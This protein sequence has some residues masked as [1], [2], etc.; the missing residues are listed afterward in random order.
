MAMPAPQPGLAEAPI[1]RTVRP[2]GFPGHR[3][4][5]GYCGI[6]AIAAAL[7]RHV[8]AYWSMYS[9]SATLTAVT[10]QGACPE[11]CRLYVVR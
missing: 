10:I 2:R 5:R 1:L 8:N 9:R 11:I 7:M 4:R 6:S 3:K